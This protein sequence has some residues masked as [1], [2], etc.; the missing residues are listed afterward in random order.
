MK[1][2]LSVRVVEQ[3]HSKR[4]ASMP[5]EDLAELAEAEGYQA[6]CMRASQVGVHT[7][8]KEGEEKRRQLDERGLPVSMVT[9]DFPIPENTDAGPAALRHI[10]PYL[11]LAEALGA[12]LLRLAMKKEEDI[13]WARRAADEAA[14]R[15]LRLAHQCH[16]LSLF[17]QVEDSLEVLE[18]IGRDNFGIIY[19]PAN[20]ELCGQDYGPQT[21]RRFKPHLFNV[22]LQNQQ[23]KSDGQSA[24]STWSG[25]EVRFDQIPLW[26]EGGIDFPLILSTLEEI[27]YDGYVTIHQA[28]AGLAGPREAAQQSARYLRSLADFE[29]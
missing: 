12:D 25:G 17:E 5:L 24:L 7:P 11:D 1:L 20:L 28:F 2:A 22:Y 29:T 19:E 26:Q 23:I 9:G 18:R 14:E 13:E 3:F 4:E 21:I 10:T 6:L 27:G 8:L 16:T 15:G